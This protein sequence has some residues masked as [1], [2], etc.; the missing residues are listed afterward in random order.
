KV[1]YLSKNRLR[2]APETARRCFEP[3][4]EDRLAGGLARRVEWFSTDPIALAGGGAVTTGRMIQDVW[5]EADRWTNSPSRITHP[6]KVSVAVV[7]PHV[8]AGFRTAHRDWGGPRKTIEEF[9]PG[10]A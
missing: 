3:C 6:T 4:I 5:S 1:I 2:F 9:D 7:A 10:S 8:N